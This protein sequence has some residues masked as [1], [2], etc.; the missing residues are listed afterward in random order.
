MWTTSGLL[1]CWITSKVLFIWGKIS[2][3]HCVYTTF[4]ISND[5]ELKMKKKKR[6]Y[7]INNRSQNRCRVNILMRTNYFVIT[8]SW[9][10]VYSHERSKISVTS[11]IFDRHILRKRIFSYWNLRLIEAVIKYLPFTRLGINW[12]SFEPSIWGKQFLNYSF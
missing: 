12:S 7:K 8:S 6:I 2:C 3:T 9:D 5:E 10:I 11:I 1:G 4:R